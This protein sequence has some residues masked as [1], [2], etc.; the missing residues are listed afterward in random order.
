MYAGINPRFSA[1]VSGV[2]SSGSSKRSVTS[3]PEQP[4]IRFA[5]YLVKLRVGEA[6]LHL[7]VLEEHRVLDRPPPATQERERA[8]ADRGLERLVG[9]QRV[10]ERAVERRGRA[11][12]RREFDASSFL[13]HLEIDDAR[14]ADAHAFGELG[15]GHPER[16]AD[17]LDPAARG[18]LEAFRGTELREAF[19]ETPT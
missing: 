12:Q 8:L 18:R 1:G 6:V 19:V 4:G 10:D 9:D 13:R 16:L 2:P 7:L 17:G 14:L 11:A 5:Q 3:F 15:R